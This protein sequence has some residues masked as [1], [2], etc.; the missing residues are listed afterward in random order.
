MF[1]LIED[2]AD[3]WV[4]ALFADRTQADYLPTTFVTFT[5][6]KTILRKDEEQF[7]EWDEDLRRSLAK[8]RLLGLIN[9]TLPRP[10]I[11]KSSKARIWQEL[12][13]A[14]AIW[15]WHNIS[16]ELKARIKL[17]AGPIRRG[18]ADTLYDATVEEMENPDILTV[19][20]RF[21]KCFNMTGSDFSLLSEYVVSFMREIMILKRWKIELSPYMVIHRILHNLSEE[22]RSKWL[23][24]MKREQ[25]TAASFTDAKLIE[26][27]RK[28]RIELIYDEKN[29]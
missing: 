20:D 8:D 21:N 19:Q 17:T 25:D 13:S 1:T 22:R 4:A 15:I 10:K 12:S 16:A 23:E 14:L 11:D 29:S 18:Y 7:D 26:Y 2:D 28:I 5:E 3:G 9:S 24:T 6:M 27:T